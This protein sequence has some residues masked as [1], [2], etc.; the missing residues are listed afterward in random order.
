MH[1]C[2]ENF[3]FFLFLKFG[4]RRPLAFVRLERYRPLGRLLM[5]TAFFEWPF[6]VI[7]FGNLFVVFIEKCSLHHVGDLCRPYQNF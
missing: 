6:S 4:A 5:S 3:Q 7:F 2:I 1:H